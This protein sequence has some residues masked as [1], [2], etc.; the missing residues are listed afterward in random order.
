MCI[1]DSSS[2][3][4]EPQPATPSQISPEPEVLNSP[5]P[6]TA[7]VEETSTE[8]GAAIGELETPEP[9]VELANEKPDFEAPPRAVIVEDDEVIL[10]PEEDTEVDPGPT[11][12]AV[13]GELET[14]TPANFISY[15]VVRGDTLSGISRRYKVSIA[16]IKEAN[17]FESDDLR[18]NQVLKVPT[19]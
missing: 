6:V 5:N 4:L 13:N 7:A 15:K 14:A 17:G 16:A 10:E 2:G 19:Q 18:I 1:R 8:V 11:P 9:V 12:P 3:V